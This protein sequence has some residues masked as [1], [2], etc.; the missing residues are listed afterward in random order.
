VQGLFREPKEDQDNLE[1]KSA[2]STRILGFLGSLIIFWIVLR[3]LAPVLS[4]AWGIVWVEKPGVRAGIAVFLALPFA[5]WLARIEGSI[6]GKYYVIIGYL[7]CLALIVWIV[8]RLL[9]YL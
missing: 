7:L 5:V 6:W 3:E 4:G 8:L 1:T 9:H 2:W